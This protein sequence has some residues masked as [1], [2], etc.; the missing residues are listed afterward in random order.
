M[1]H[2]DSRACRRHRGR[3]ARTARSRPRRQGHRRCRKTYDDEFGWPLAR[4]RLPTMSTPIC[5]GAD[6]GAQT[7]RWLEQI[8]FGSTRDRHCDPPGFGDP[9]AS[10]G[11]LWLL[12]MTISIP[13]QRVPGPPSRLP[14]KFTRANNLNGL[15]ALS[16]N[17]FRFGNL[18]VATLRAMAIP[19]SR[20]ALWRPFRFRPRR[21]PNAAK[22][23]RIF[24]LAKRA[25]L[26][27]DP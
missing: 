26:Q 15:A 19:P 22:T 5:A 23:K 1:P 16:R 18:S 2:R 20:S 21:G 6:A 10:V 8:A 4:Y 7:K 12:A 27:H 24:P 9:R 17:F 11:A 13:T 14:H 3:R 25:V